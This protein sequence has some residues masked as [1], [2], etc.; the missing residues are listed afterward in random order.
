MPKQAK[1]LLFLLLFFLAVRAKAQID[2]SYHYNVNA[3]V[4]C[5]WSQAATADS[6]IVWA[7]VTLPQLETKDFYMSYQLADDEIGRSIFYTDSIQPSQLVSS[8]SR[9]HL[10]S[11]HLTSKR[12]KAKWIFLYF[13]SKKNSKQLVFFHSIEQANGGLYLQ[14]AAS[15]PMA[16]RF[17]RQGEIFSVKTLRPA[18]SLLWVYYYSQDFPQADIPMESTPVDSK[19]KLDSLFQIKPNFPF[20]SQKEGLYLIKT[21]TSAKCG[22]SFIMKDPY[23][24]R[25]AQIDDVINSL[26]YITTD[27]EYQILTSSLEKKKTLDR[28][29][30]N[31]FKSPD[32]AKPTIRSY[33]QKVE[34]ANLLFSNYKEG[35]KTDQGMIYII[36]GAPLE[37][38]SYGNKEEW[39]YQMPEDNSR[40]SFTFVEVNT[41]FGGSFYA[42]IREKRHSRHWHKAL[43]L[44][45]IGRK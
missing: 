33:Y 37:V 18:D 43:E 36:Y 20:Q 15:V 8:G 16:S 22:L 12:D 28:F 32:R 6:L 13:K 1:S 34:E 5:T 2:L 31:L 26:V 3:E 11:F 44:W 14:D 45:R 25:H 17:V 10:M 4:T 9:N 35:W 42:L 21:D 23:Y 30:L 40:I 41:I 24:P 27:N 19:M 38:Y 39:I 29:W 7:R